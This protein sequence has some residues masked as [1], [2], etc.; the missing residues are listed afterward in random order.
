MEYCNQG[1][2]EDL[3]LKQ[4][5]QRFSEYQS[6]QFM[7][8]I[9]IGLRELHKN[10]IIHRDIKIQNLLVQNQIIKIADFG[11]SIITED[12]ARTF[13][14]TG[15][16]MSPEV[17]N[18]QKYTVKCD[19]YSLGVLFYFLLTG[20]YPFWEKNKSKQIQEQLELIKKQE[21]DFQIEGVIIS[22]K[23]Q[24]LI[25][26]M[27]K[28]QECDRIDM[29]GVWDS[30]VF[31]ETLNQK[32]GFI[33]MSN[34]FC[35]P[36]EFFKNDKKFYKN[37]IEFDDWKKQEIIDQKRDQMMLES[38]EKQIINNVE[39][40]EKQLDMLNLM[41]D[42][43]FT[44]KEDEEEEL[45]DEQFQQKKQ[46]EI[47]KFIEEKYFY[48]IN[49][50][51]ILSFCCEKIYVLDSQINPYRALF[52]MFKKLI[53]YMQEFLD[54]IKN[55]K[56]MFN[57]KYPRSLY[58]NEIMN[59]VQ[60]L[61]EEVIL[62]SN[63]YYMIV[64][65]QNQDFYQYYKNQ[66]KNIELQNQFKSGMYNKDSQKVFEIYVKEYLNRIWPKQVKNQ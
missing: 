22:D 8:Q 56:N 62:L 11:L 47:Q 35:F 9:L 60:N 32:K 65:I 18:K 33:S 38:S 37:S 36:F 1:T 40:L 51:R 31:S 46:E 30:P 41:G 59:Q 21:I 52:M 10:G 55:R 42:K 54:D 34:I 39:Y 3:K 2:L 17:L 43:K 29:A 16:Y 24:N 61:L 57:C 58:N 48:P 15:P 14:G 49:C 19:V 20:K 5:N 23:T 13:C 4:D 45:K 64:L 66:Y 6:I 53:F 26:N 63:E 12:H 50:Y 28:F 7:T 25:K 44:E 27:L